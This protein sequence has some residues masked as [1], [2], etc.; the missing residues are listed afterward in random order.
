MSAITVG[1]PSDGDTV[2]MGPLVS[3]AHRDRVHAM[4]TRARTDGATI[5]VGGTPIDGP[6]NFYPP[7]VITDAP[8]GGEI[9][10]EEIFGPV[11]TI[12][13]FRDEADALDL[14]NG[15]PYGLAASV[16]TQNIGRALRLSSALNFGTVWVNTHL[17]LTSEMPWVGY[18][19]SGHGR[20]CSTLSIDDF[21]RTKHVM[22]ATTP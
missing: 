2:E 14:A 3:A 11:I 15:T 16:W 22:I 19:D 10:T 21:S 17:I 9:T 6:G 12:E 20:E 18:G 7:T 13:T 1:N 8:R 4:V 5:A